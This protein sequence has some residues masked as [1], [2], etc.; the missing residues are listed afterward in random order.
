[1]EIHD[2]KD[3]IF[4]QQIFQ[5]GSG[6]LKTSYTLFLQRSYRHG[7]FSL[8]YPVARGTGPLLSTIAVVLA[9]LR[10]WR[11][12]LIAPIVCHA[13]VNAVTVTMLVLMTG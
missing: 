6:F 2:T 7:D 12:S 11:G 9:A 8:V 3:R 5:C 10:E 13:C 4:G 1:M